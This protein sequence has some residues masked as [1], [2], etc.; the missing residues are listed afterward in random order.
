L[1]NNQVQEVASE[2][3]EMT[4]EQ[5]TPIAKDQLSGEPNN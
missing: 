4:D 5:K 3:I 2:D 1:S